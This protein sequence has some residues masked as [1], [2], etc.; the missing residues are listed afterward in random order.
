MSCGGTV[1]LGRVAIL[2][3][4]PSLGKGAHPVVHMANLDDVASYGHVTLLNYRAHSGGGGHFG[5][6]SLSG[7]HSSLCIPP[8]GHSRP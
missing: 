1:S 8:L 7:T 3:C 4:V 6:L 2:D 5:I